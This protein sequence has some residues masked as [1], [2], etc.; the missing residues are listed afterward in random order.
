MPIT[1]I[2]IVGHCGFDSGSLTRFAEQ[3]APVA[4]VVRVNDQQSLDAILKP[5]TLLLIN[6][7]LDGRFSAGGSGIDMIRDLEA[8]ED[9]PATM[10]VSNYEDAQQ[11]AMAAGALRGFGKSH[12]GDSSTRQ[13]VAEAIDSL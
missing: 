3:V 6:R 2:A 1:H 12:L 13:R 10:L 9:S 7:Q 5:Q 11:Q 4:T 8:Q